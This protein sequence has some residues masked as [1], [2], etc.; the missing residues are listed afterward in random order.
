MVTGGQA[1]CFNI[2][3]LSLEANVYGKPNFTLRNERKD[4]RIKELDL[5]TDLLKL[6]FPNEIKEDRVLS[7]YYGK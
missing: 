5:L 7:P 2:S 3:E 4:G 1:G 6:S